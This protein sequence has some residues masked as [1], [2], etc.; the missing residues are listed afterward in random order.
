MDYSFTSDEKS[1]DNLKIT[2]TDTAIE[3]LELS[4]KRNTLLTALRQQEKVLIQ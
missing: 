3:T 4:G 2:T 1:T